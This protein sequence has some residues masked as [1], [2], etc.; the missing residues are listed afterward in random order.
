MAEVDTN[1]ELRECESTELRARES[2]RERERERERESSV[3][4]KLSLS[5]V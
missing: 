3:R 1:S 5:E 4:H 2:E